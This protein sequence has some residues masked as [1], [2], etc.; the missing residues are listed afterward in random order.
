[1]RHGEFDSDTVALQQRLQTHDRYG[2]RDLNEWIF[3]IL[4]PK[5]GDKILDLGCGTGKQ[6]IPLAKTVGE[7]G[8]VVALDV[9]QQ[10]VDAVSEYVRELGLDQLVTVICGSLDDVGSLLGDR[11]F[12]RIVASFSIYYVEDPERLFRT[13]RD[14]S[15][16]RGALFFCGPSATNNSEIIAFH[17]QVKGD[18]AG[19]AGTADA[20]MQGEGQALAREYFTNVELYEFENPIRF[21]SADALCDYWMS[22]NLYDP[23]IETKFREA[24]EDHFRNNVHFKTTKRVI[25][26]CAR[27]PHP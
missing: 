4:T 12:D 13:L 14:L 9:S 26:V 3:S 6:A 22:Y 24:A 18:A 17:N 1:M 19:T 10:A 8:H 27:C 16:P 15:A 20:F 11:Q 2:T 5:P 25:G 23:A 21:D 7:A